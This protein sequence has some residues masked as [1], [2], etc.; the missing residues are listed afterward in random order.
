MSNLQ[1]V[2]MKSRLP[3]MCP[4]PRFPKPNDRGFRR[5]TDY[6]PLMWDEFFT[7]K[8]DVETKQGKFRVYLTGPS[9][10]G[11]PLLVLLHGGGFSALSWAHFSSE[12][13]KLI[14]CQCLAFDIRGHGD[15]YTE[16]E[17]DLSAERLATDVGDVIQAM[18]DGSAPP[19]ILMGHSMGG[20]ICVHTANMYVIP[21][22][23]GVVVIDVVEG[24]ALE[25]L[26]SMQS[27]L[28]SRPTT[29]KSIQHAIEWCVRSG[30][31]R[32]VESA[33]VSMPGQIIN[34]ETKQLAT[35]ELPL[36]PEPSSEEKVEFKHPNAIAEDAE[37]SSSPAT[38]A[39]PSDLPS[40]SSSPSALN[41][42]KY[43]W[44]IDLSKSEKYWEGWFSGLSQKFLD[45]PVPKLLLLAGIDNLDRA[46]T[47]GQMQ[48][49]FQLQ[50]LARCGH[51]VHED[52]PHEVAEVLATYL[53]RNKFAQ[54]TGDGL[55]LKHMP[56][57]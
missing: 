2:M 26:A 28:R 21:S 51:A 46:L 18:Y 34:I 15:T 31:V 41:L 14:H 49:K 33:R 35:N 10:P 47:V 48:G 8:K 6:N 3:P 20:A 39:P 5:Q 44:R 56:A 11:A 55:L 37:S 24:T 12:I 19:I 9:E 52:R 36:K 25:A 30:Q 32:N 54:P 23:L 13:T 38:E 27:F 43:G 1:R 7:E 22:L 29:F 42:R 16:E 53:I 50:V 40:P 57:C 45:V 4:N 17:D